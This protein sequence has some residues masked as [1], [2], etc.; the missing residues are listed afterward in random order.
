MRFFQELF[1]FYEKNDSPINNNK[2]QM[3][4][5]KEVTESFADSTGNS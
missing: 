5:N 1:H 2:I 4:P 3:A